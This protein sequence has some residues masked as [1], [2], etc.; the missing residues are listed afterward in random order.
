MVRI[1][2]IGAGIVG[3]TTAVNVQKMVPD[4]RV[5]IFA[6]KFGNDTTSSGAGGIYRPTGQLIKGVSEETLKKWVTDSWEYFSSLAMSPLAKETGQTLAPLYKDIVFHFRHLTPEELRKLNFK[7]KYGCFFTT[8]I[9][10]TKKFMPWLMTQFKEKGGKV[11]FR[12]V[13]KIEE[14]ADFD[15]VVNCS[16]LGS[17]QMLQ[18]RSMYP[19]KGQ[20]VHVKAPWIKTFVYCEGSPEP[21][22]FIP[23]DDYIIIGGT[24]ERGNYQKDFSPATQEDILRR[25]ADIL[26]QVKEGEVVGNWTG[27]R[28]SRDPIRLEKELLFV[29][30]KKLR[31]VHNYGHGANGVSLSWG[32]AKVAAQL[33][34][35]WA[36]EIPRAARL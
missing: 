3:L 15:I 12:T 33:T 20:L 2:V 13:T 28:P 7:S 31:V 29:N 18:D 16:A 8:V 14:L 30:G 11:E 22:Y 24:R 25:A 10:Q 9:T 4:A 19:V 21:T 17:Q 26:P 27:L 5:T 23:H 35:E 34:K 1:A 6:D 32:T 36:D